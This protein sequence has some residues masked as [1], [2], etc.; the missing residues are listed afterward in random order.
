ML[1]KAK[2]NVETRH[3]ANNRKKYFSSIWKVNF[4]LFSIYPSNIYLYTSQIHMS[5][6]VRQSHCTM[7][8]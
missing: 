2:D 3:P 5:K 8:T 1:N 6:L 4:S 7:G